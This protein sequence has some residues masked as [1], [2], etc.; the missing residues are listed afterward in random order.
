MRLRLTVTRSSIPQLPVG[1]AKEFA[2]PG[3]TLGRQNADFVLPDTEKRVSRLH[4]EVS[5][6]GGRVAVRDTSHN[7]TLVNG[8]N[9]GNGNVAALVHGD[10]L[11]IGPYQLAVALFD[12][13]P[14][15]ELPD[16]HLSTHD[17]TPDPFRNRSNGGGRASFPASPFGLEPEG[18]AEVDPLLALDRVDSADGLGFDVA[19]DP[20]GA[21]GYNAPPRRGVTAPHPDSVGPS[22]HF[23]APA[24]NPAAIPNDYEITGY[25]NAEQRAPA[26]PRPHAAPNV[27]HSIPAV[28]HPVRHVA[29]PAVNPSRETNAQPPVASAAE[30]G[31]HAFLEGA[32]MLPEHIGGGDALAHLERAGALFRGL[33]EGLMGLLEAR[34]RL[35]VEFR[36]TQ[37]IV[38]R[39]DNNPLKF[40]GNTD[41]ALYHL[42]GRP[43]PGYLP[44][45]QAV[46]DGMRD[47][48]E[49]EL[50]TIAGIHAAIEALV[51]R[52]DPAAIEKQLE[53]RRGRSA[54]PMFNRSGKLWDVYC[55][56]YESRVRDVDEHFNDL[57]GEEFNR[58]YERVTSAAGYERQSA[59][60]VDPMAS[61]PGRKR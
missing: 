28:E 38:T 9:I 2:A 53:R 14:E 32:G 48:K 44:P 57:W 59:G 15:I 20:F 8:A 10:S 41:A 23:S 1:S 19:L 36:L 12:A 13:E 45:E 3:F 50:A 58:A 26:A 37:T 24:L 42:L 22:A 17:G 35:K 27:A 33:V 40:S 16:L 43:M 52:F 11:E 7:G 54:L 51:K 60:S 31:W 61:P 29:P 49:H 55:D 34:T 30:A 56:F 47:V 4:A 5:F 6:S 21:A 46:A 25:Q 39:A 18:H